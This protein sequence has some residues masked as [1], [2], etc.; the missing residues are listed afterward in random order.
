M[1]PK[2]AV[3]WNSLLECLDQAP[4][5]F[6]RQAS[7]LYQQRRV[8][9]VSSPAAR[10]WGGGRDSGV[11][12][13]AEQQGR[14][15][16]AYAS[17]SETMLYFGEIDDKG[18]HIRILQP[19]RVVG[20]AARHV[21]V[22]AAFTLYCF[23]MNPDSEP[24]FWSSSATG[25]LFGEYYT[26]WTPV[27]RYRLLRIR[28]TRIFASDILAAPQLRE[29]HD[30]QLSEPDRA[31]ERLCSVCLFAD[32]YEY[33][34]WHLVRF[35]DTLPPDYGRPQNDVERPSW[36]RA[37]ARTPQHVL[38][39]LDR[40]VSSSQV[41][42]AYRRLAMRHHPDRGGDALSFHRIT[43]AYRKLKRLACG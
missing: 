22:V 14:W 25:G 31:W 12:S 26:G 29:A 19:V 35:R 40:N 30:P 41:T 10:S 5:H 4:Q 8:K 36:P 6:L 24:A 13:D 23:R 39:G 28:K 7:R 20:Q 42:A 9:P 21:H 3:D 38:L 37:H 34:K 33:A 16:R 11:S 15:K 27:T 32:E 1:N 17:S 43:D 2:H 18:E